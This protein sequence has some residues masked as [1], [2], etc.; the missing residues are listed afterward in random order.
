MPEP[1]RNGAHRTVGARGLVLAP[2]VR[3]RVF[4]AVPPSVTVHRIPPEI[5]PSETA[6]GTDPGHLISKPTGP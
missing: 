6:G 3:L 1:K 4:A 5:L 2:V